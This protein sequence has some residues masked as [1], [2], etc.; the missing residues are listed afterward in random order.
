MPA[1]APAGMYTAT[2][3]DARASWVVMPDQSMIGVQ[4]RTSRRDDELI[5]QILRDQQALQDKVRQARL[6]RQVQPAPK[7]TFGTWS[8]DAD[9]TTVTAVPGSMTSLPRTN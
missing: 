3:G 4:N 1:A 5:G 9:G 7:M 8:M 6:D 2:F